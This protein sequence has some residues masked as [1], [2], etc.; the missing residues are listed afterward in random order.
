MLKKVKSGED[1]KFNFGG[2][3]CPCK[4]FNNP[5]PCKCSQC[6]TYRSQQE[7]AEVRREFEEEAEK[8]WWY[9]GLKGFNEGWM[10]SM[11]SAARK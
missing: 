3:F 5:D 10:E 7:D 8:N 11:E 6:E 4:D 9:R 1:Y 2:L